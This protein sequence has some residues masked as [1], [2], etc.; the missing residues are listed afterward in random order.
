[1]ACCPASGASVC[2]VNTCPTRPTS[3]CRRACLPSA[4]AIPAASWPRCCN[5]NK[6]KNESCAASVSVEEIANTP[7]SSCGAS[8]SNTRSSCTT[9]LGVCLCHSAALSSLL[10]GNRISNCWVVRR[11]N[12]CSKHCCIYWFGYV[13]ASDTWWHAHA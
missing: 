2:G 1:M 12:F 8:P 5:A 3:L 4:T 6:P 7:H 11:K 13:C 9:N 10:G